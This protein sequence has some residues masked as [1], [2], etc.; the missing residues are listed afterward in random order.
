MQ[1]KIRVNVTDQWMA[2]GF[3]CVYL[4]S[5]SAGHLKLCTEPPMGL[6]RGECSDHQTLSAMA[7]DRRSDS[8]QDR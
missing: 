6:S 5:A 8:P 7:L 1:P 3:I 4:V 2:S